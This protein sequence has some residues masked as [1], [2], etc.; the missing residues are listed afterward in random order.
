MTP[1]AQDARLG[2]GRATTG[3]KVSLAPQPHIPS[4]CHVPSGTTSGRAAFLGRDP[5]HQTKVV[6]VH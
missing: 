1:F 6:T 3:T 5:G 4:A 2:S